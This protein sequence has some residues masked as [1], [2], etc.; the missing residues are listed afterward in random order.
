VYEV[1]QK[2][3]QLVIDFFAS[4]ADLR[5]IDFRTPLCFESIRDYFHTMTRGV[6]KKHGSEIA[7]FREGLRAVAKE[8]I[9]I[10]AA[11][12]T[13]IVKHSELLLK[14]GT[15]KKVLV[16]GYSRS[17]ALSLKRL[18]KS[19]DE[20]LTVLVCRSGALEEGYRSC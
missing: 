5:L 15:P 20:S 1:V 19:L 14:D 13:R 17:I 10:M 7:K 4:E 11:S 2:E 9:D 8:L 12:T 18:A 3:Y 16:F 6:Y